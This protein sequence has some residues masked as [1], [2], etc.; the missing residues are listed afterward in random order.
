MIDYIYL[1]LI[2][3]L[4]CFIIFIINLSY[5]YRI[6]E[7]FTLSP[8]L[9]KINPIDID[10][11]NYND[12]KFANNYTN[13]LIDTQNK[14]TLKNNII[15]LELL[16]KSAENLENAKYIDKVLNQHLKYFLLIN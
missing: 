14:Q 4:I 12:Q 5:E 15:N 3:C 2:V 8:E 13:F 1:V 11:I 10:L 16:D 6:K 7:G 9:S